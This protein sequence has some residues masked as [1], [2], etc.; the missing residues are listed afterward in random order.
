MAL[1]QEGHGDAGA[2]SELPTDM[3]PASSE[4]EWT[5]RAALTPLLSGSERSQM[6]V[7]AWGP[8]RSPVDRTGPPRTLSPAPSH[9]V[10][11]QCGLV[12]TRAGPREV[13]CTLAPP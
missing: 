6:L 5:R 8:R 1:T 3:G 4:P 12:E 2:A 7:S 13:S 9:T 11:V 10:G